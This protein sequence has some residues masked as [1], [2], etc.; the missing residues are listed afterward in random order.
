MIA[1]APHT[2]GCWVSPLNLLKS[3][4]IDDGEA[5]VEVSDRF[6]LEREPS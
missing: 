3:L 2:F 4:A 6:V 5:Q 1:G